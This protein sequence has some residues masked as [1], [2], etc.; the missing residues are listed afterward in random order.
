VLHLCNHPFVAAGADVHQAVMDVL[1]QLYRTPVAELL[2]YAAVGAQVVSGWTLFRQTRGAR[3]ERRWRRYSGAFLSLFLL[4]HGLAA[5]YQRHVVGLDS[6]AYWAA[7]VLAWPW[8][9][10]F[11]P[12]YTL[13]VTS[14]VVHIGSVFGVRAVRSGLLGVGLAA[15]IVLGLSGV[16]HPLEI[17]AAYRR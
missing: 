9:I 14:F 10:W 15:V 4:A 1:R 17:P 3:G 16:F 5:Q 12:Y 13:G 8:A 2:L 6:N 7:A 11:V